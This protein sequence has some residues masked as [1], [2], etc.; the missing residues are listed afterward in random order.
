MRRSFLKEVFG[1][2]AMLFLVKSLKTLS[3][4]TMV[5]DFLRPINV[6]GTPRSSDTWPQVVLTLQICSLSQES[7]MRRACLKEVFGR[8]AM[9]FLVMC[10]KKLSIE[11][12]VKDL[13]KPNDGCNQN[14]REN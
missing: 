3:I 14:L 7:T 13:L 10:L 11:T 4:E 2:N 8:I 12:M 5:K 1:R 6:S 9:L